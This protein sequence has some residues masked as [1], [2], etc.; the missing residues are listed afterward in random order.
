MG[1]CGDVEDRGEGDIKGVC[2]PMEEGEVF[3]AVSLLDKEEDALATKVAVGAREVEAVVV[4]I[5][6]PPLVAVGRGDLEPPPPSPPIDGESKGVEEGVVSPEE[7]Q[8]F[9]MVGVSVGG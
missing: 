5:E 2:V 3:T 7:L 1:A 4:P 6:M 8:E 9:A